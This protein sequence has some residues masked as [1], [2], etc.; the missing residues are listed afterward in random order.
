MIDHIALGALIATSVLGAQEVHGGAMSEKIIGMYV[1]QHW[2]YNHPYAARTWTLDDWRGYVDGLHRLGYNTILIW[3]VL[4]TTPNPLTDS[5]HANIEKIAK[6][7]DMF[8]NEFGMK[9]Y[10]TISPN[11][12]AKND[13]AAKYTF[14]KRPFFYCDYRVD[15]GDAVA[16]GKMIAWR[17]RLFRP[18]ATM[19]GLVIIDSDPGG[20]PGSTNIEFVNLL[21]AHR[22]ML[23]RLRP[24]IEIVYWIHAGWEAYCRY[25]ATAEFAMGSDEEVVDTVRLLAT[26]NPE[27]WGLTGGRLPSIQATGQGARMFSFPYGAIEGEPSFPMTNFGSDVAYNTGKSPGP[28]GIMGNSQTHCIQLPNTFAF[29]RGAQSLPCTEA[30]YIQFADDLI[31]GQGETTVAAWKA[32][33][34]VDAPQMTAAEAR[35]KALAA[36]QLSP[37]PMK[38]LLLGDPQRFVSDLVMQL[39]LRATL[40]E[41][42]RAVFAQPMDKT[43]VVSRFGEFIAAAENWQKQHNYKNNWSWPRMEEALRRLG[44]A[45][46][47][48]ALDARNYK[49]D[50]KT[51][52]EKVQNGFYKVET[53]APQL[54]EAMKQALNAM[55]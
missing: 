45:T 1:H 30:D 35:L 43:Q 6:V 31:P 12:A 4:E 47:D 28:R 21:V 23:D 44:D 18:L 2:A 13:V 42:H 9:A 10:L 25:Y 5:D 16:L 41:F 54:I 15:P 40:E 24:G 39:R 38:G 14:Q 36:D 8:H 17:E 27:P 26:R 53:Y 20:Y 52:F 46:V 33:A 22:S 7:I 32:L 48:A 51:P 19:D 55:K 50:G 34:G 3:P 49:G 29:A 11:A 37:G